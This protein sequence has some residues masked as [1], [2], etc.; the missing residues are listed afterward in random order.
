MAKTI[1]VQF[2]GEDNVSNKAKN[3]EK[4]IT[5][6]GK[7]SSSVANTMDNTWKNSV[8]RIGKLGNEFRFISLALTAVATGSIFLTKSFVD[9]A[10]EIEQAQLKLGV[11]AASAGENFDEVTAAAQRLY[12]TGLIP[13]NEASAGLA[14]LLATGIGLEKSEK[15]MTRFLDAASVAKESLTD[16]LG[17]AI[18]KATLGFRIFQERQVDAVGVNFKMEESIKRVAKELFGQSTNLT[19]TQRHLALYNFLMQETERYVGS[20]ELATQTFSGTMSKLDANL[21]MLRATL[22]ATLIPLIASFADGLS[23]VSDNVR[24]FAEKFP[25]LTSAILVGTTSLIVFTASMAGLGAIIPLVAKGFEAFSQAAFFTMSRVA[26]VSLAKFAAMAIAI[27]GLTFLIL[28]ATGQWD[29]WRN[30]M[31]D[32]TSRISE[33]ISPMKELGNEVSETNKKLTKQIQTLEQNITLATRDFTESMREWVTSHD[34]TVKELGTQIST[35]ER[36]YKTSTQNIRDDFK[37]MN[38][39]LVLSHSRKVED[40]QKQL[41]EEVS[42]GIW[43]DQTRIRE[44][45]LSLKR[46]NEDYNNASKKN[47]ARRDDDLTKEKT[48]YDDRLSELQTKLDAELALEKKHANLIAQARA[49][50]LLDEIEKRSRAYQERVAQY[51]T[52]LSELRNNNAAIVASNDKVIDSLTGIADASNEPISKVQ[53][54]GTEFDNAKSRADDMNTTMGTVGTVISTEMIKSIKFIKKY[55]KWVGKTNYKLDLLA[56]K[57]LGLDMS[58][59][60]TLAIGVYRGINALITGLS[61]GVSSSTPQFKEGGIIPGNTNQ[62]VPIIA[63]G[64]ET[65]LPAG[66]QPVTIN[67]NNPTVRNESDIQ[68]IA[69]VVKQVLSAQQ[70]FRHIT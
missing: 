54:L 13:L 18:E 59:G 6:L 51:A 27:G 9:A 7:K 49:W 29:K 43:A 24:S 15:L 11:F 45:Q 23:S 65:V 44:L 46:E 70:R 53:E 3:V 60:E 30:S 28:K 32:L 69:R 19:T 35:L 17:K 52:E 10:K 33:I 50:P 12:G 8:E 26:V 39:D 57:L 4:S 40:I 48:K 34:K 2:K 58:L 67:I 55:Y 36:D 31:K 5:N 41:D 42:K 68:E 21:T 16:T 38:D 62:A 20:A 22:G 63:H 66:V 64:G 61:S 47:D 56:G 14:N 25:G 1:L 37:R